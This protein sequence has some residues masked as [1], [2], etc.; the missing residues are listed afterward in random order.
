MEEGGGEGG[1]LPAV[2][3]KA[4]ASFVAWR[5]RRPTLGGMEEEEEEEEE[6]RRRWCCLS[7]RKDK[8]DSERLSFKGSLLA[9]GL[10]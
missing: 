3:G 6:F 2:T 8:P 4:S 1:I 10:P 7:L 9:P 5:Q